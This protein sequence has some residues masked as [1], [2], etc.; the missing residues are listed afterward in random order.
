MMIRVPSQVSVYAPGY[1]GPLGLSGLGQGDTVDIGAGDT[2]QIPDISL[3]PSTPV[4][5]TTIDT[6]GGGGGGLS[7][8]QIAKIL[9]TAATGAV[10]IVRST[11]SPYVIPGTNSVFDPAT[12]RILA[13]GQSNLTTPLVS[14]TISNTGLLVGGAVAIGILVLIFAMKR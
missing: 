7:V 3:T 2:L 13:P 4:D 8:D 5:T 12:G 9:G 10:N 11:S 1:G 14:G 6:S